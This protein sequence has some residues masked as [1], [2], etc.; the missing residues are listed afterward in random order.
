MGELELPP[1]LVQCEVCSGRERPAAIAHNGDGRPVAV[2][3]RC[4][5]G[6]SVALSLLERLTSKPGLIDFELLKL[7]TLEWTPV[8][9]TEAPSV[10]ATSSAAA[11]ADSSVAAAALVCAVCGAHCR[12]LLGDYEW[13]G[14]HL[15][16]DCFERLDQLDRDHVYPAFHFAAAIVANRE[17]ATAEGVQ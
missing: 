15:C 14:I 10:T 7:A 4:A 1:M 2:C 9:I 6:E 17:V 13:P 16:N 11:V 5:S 8:R 12:V 3:E